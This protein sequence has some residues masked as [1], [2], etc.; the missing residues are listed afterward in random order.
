MTYRFRLN[1]MDVECDTYEEF[2]AAVKL[3]A[4]KGPGHGG[5][6]T[7]KDSDGR[8]KQTEAV[9]TAWKE[10]EEYAKKHGVT[11]NQARSILAEKRRKLK[12]MVE[13]ETAK[14]L[15]LEQKKR[16]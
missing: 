3:G 5:L 15:A 2:E 6:R 7:M 4:Q 11:K 14:K 10:A 1:G 16:R 12:K 13:R 8:K 9:A